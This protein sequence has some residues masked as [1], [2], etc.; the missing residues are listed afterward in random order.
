[1]LEI[2]YTSILSSLFISYAMIG[3]FSWK[4][5]NDVNQAIT[6]VI[7]SSK[8]L[9]KQKDLL[10]LAKEKKSILRYIFWPIALFK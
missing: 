9:K 7:S 1:M 10:A 4:L 6:K 2:F 5:E 3:I 8:N